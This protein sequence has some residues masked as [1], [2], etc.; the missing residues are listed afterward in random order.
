VSL[1]GHDA[2]YLTVVWAIACAL[3]VVASLVMAVLFRRARKTAE[4]EEIDRILAEHGSEG[5]SNRRA[6]HVSSRHGDDA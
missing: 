3:G 4:V 6:S 5:E 1:A 2:H